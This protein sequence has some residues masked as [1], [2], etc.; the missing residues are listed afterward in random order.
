MLLQ[1]NIRNDKGKEST[2]SYVCP[3]LLI[4]STLQRS[5]PC[6]LLQFFLLTISPLP[7]AFE[8]HL[9]P[10]ILDCARPPLTPG[11]LYVPVSL[12]TKTFLPMAHPYPSGFFLFSLSMCILLTRSEAHEMSLPASK[13]YSS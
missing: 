4:A 9:Y 13:T 3:T 11:P 2:E 1:K 5:G 6:L 8:P 12:P 7:F 10:Q